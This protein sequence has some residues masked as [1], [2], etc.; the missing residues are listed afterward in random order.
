[1]CACKWAGRDAASNRNRHRHSAHTKWAASGTGER[2]G[3]REMAERDGW[4]Y[5]PV[6]KLVCPSAI[7]FALAHCPVSLAFMYSKKRQRGSKK[8]RERALGL[9]FGAAA[10]AAISLLLYT[11][12]NSPALSLA[13]AAWVL[14]LSPRL[15]MCVCVCD[16]N[17]NEKRRSKAYGWMS[18]GMNLNPGNLQH[19][20]ERG[21]RGRTGSRGG[22]RFVIPASHRQKLSLLCAQSIV[23]PPIRA[24]GATSF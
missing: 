17:T 12:G 21:G 13:R 15:F 11:L 6:G 2:A 22:G 23:L 10:R 16:R 8:E 20:G 9:L 3:R 14:L 7:S 5:V 4:M 24:G 19:I 18:C 1:M